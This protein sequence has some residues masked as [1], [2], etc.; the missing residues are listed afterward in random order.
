MMLRGVADN[1]PH[2]DPSEFPG[3]RYFSLRGEV[4]FLVLD[5]YTSRCHC[6]KIHESK[7]S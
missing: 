6:A 3:D 1:P 2:A 7:V 5:C 4:I